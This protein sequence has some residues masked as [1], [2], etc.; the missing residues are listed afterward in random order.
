MRTKPPPQDVDK[1]DR[2]FR[3]SSKKPII[4]GVCIMVSLIVLI[5]IKDINPD[6]FVEDCKT[7]LG[8]EKGAAGVIVSAGPSRAQSTQALDQVAK[9]EEAKID[10]NAPFQEKF[11]AWWN[12]VRP[13]PTRGVRAAVLTPRPARATVLPRR[14]D[15]RRKGCGAERE[16]RGPHA[17]HEVLGGEPQDDLDRHPGRHLPPLLVRAPPARGRAL[18]ARPTSRARPSFSGGP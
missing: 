18:R 16:P 13:F 14:P 17:L 2:V 4:A 8:V 10:P 3:E 12:K 11:M 7:F 5:A 9:D 1:D 6:T 15:A